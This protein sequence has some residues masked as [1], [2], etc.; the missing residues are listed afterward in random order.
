MINNTLLELPVSPSTTP[1]SACDAYP[2][3]PGD[4]PAPK[5]FTGTSFAAG[6]FLGKRFDA[7]HVGDVLEIISGTPVNVCTDECMAREACKGTCVYA[8]TYA[9]AHT[10]THTRS[11]AHPYTHTPEPRR[12]L[13]PDPDL[14]GRHVHPA[15]RRA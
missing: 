10:H 15:H 11:H 2:G 5:T 9:H 14:A 4:R 13:R 12:V 6:L 1:P 3:L 7:E 8:Y